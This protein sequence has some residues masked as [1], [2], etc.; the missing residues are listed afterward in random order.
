MC[1]QNKMIAKED[2][3]I[4]RNV[5]YFRLYT[6]IYD[7]M[8]M[9][10]MERMFIIMALTCSHYMGYNTKRHPHV[11]SYIHALSAHVHGLFRV[12]YHKTFPV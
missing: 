11:C 8:H 12:F 5:K 2:L 9:G 3:N 10:E 4:S 7:Y 1:A 6:N